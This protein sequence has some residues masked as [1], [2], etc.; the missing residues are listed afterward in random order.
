MDLQKL[1]RELWKVITRDVSAGA[2]DRGTFRTA[3]IIAAAAIVV[4]L[5]AAMAAMEYFG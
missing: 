3:G 5:V 4:A 1:A 2:F